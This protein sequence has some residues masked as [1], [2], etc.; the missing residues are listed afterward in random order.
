MGNAGRDARR[1][2]EG[3]SLS[4]PCRPTRYRHNQLHLPLHKAGLDGAYF[5]LHGTKVINDRPGAAF[6][7]Q[8]FGQNSKAF[9]NLI[10]G[11]QSKGNWQTKIEYGNFAEHLRAGDDT[12]Q[13]PEAMSFSK[14]AKWSK[15][16][17]LWPNL[18]LG[19]RT[20]PPPSAGLA[21]TPRLHAPGDR[22]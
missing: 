20:V 17:E 15:I 8:V 18:G 9:S 10:A 12:I 3:L 4:D 22:A 6:D 16:H 11:C 21:L 19:E 14:W 2:G 7:G 1:R 13:L 5:V